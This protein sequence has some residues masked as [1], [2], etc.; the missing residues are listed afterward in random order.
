M[1][2]C[3]NVCNAFATQAHSS[4]EKACMIGMVKLR[5]LEPDKKYRMRGQT[6]E[7]AILVCYSIRL[8]Q[9]LL[10]CIGRPFNG[11][12][13]VLCINNTWHYIGV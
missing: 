10:V 1:L 3:W 7:E 6:L 2:E 13:S 5:I 4:V 8:I 12:N 11:I 9:F